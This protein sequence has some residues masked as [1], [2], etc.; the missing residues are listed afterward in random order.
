MQS[1]VSGVYQN[2]QAGMEDSQAEFPRNCEKFVGSGRERSPRRSS[3][4]TAHTIAKGFVMATR[5]ST[6][7][8]PYE[9]LNL[10]T[11][12]GTAVSEKPCGTFDWRARCASRTCLR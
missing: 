11:A 12:L 6:A 9:N 2:R 4:A 1:K 7:T 5:N 10:C 3:L 8:V